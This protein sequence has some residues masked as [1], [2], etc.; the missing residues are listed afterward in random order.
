VWES[1]QADNK[2]QQEGWKE[3]KARK[4]RTEEGNVGDT[5]RVSDRDTRFNTFRR[6]L[7][8]DMNDKSKVR[9]FVRALGV[10]S[11]LGI[12]SWNEFQFRCRD[13]S[14][15]IE[16]RSQRPATS[17]FASSFNLIVFNPGSCE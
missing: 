13:E 17:L 11:R 2:D 8:P 3:R 15:D 16:R 12:D 10:E 14:F 6:D 1:H 9:A 5:N 7:S 4:R